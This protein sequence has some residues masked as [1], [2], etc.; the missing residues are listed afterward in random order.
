MIKEIVIEWNFEPKNFFEA[1]T[2]INYTDYEV[3]ISSGHAE[4]RLGPDYLDK[5]DMVVRALSQDLESRFMAVQVMTHEQY[6]LSKPSRYDLRLDGGRNGYFQVD[7]VVCT[8]SIGNVDLIQRDANGNILSDT[9][10]ERIDKKK[11]LAELAAKFRLKDASLDQMLRSYNASVSDP[12]NELIHL[13]EIRDAASK[14]FG[15]D[16]N[17]KKGLNISSSE[18]STLGR[19]ANSEP[20]TQ[21]RHRGQNPGILRDAETSELEQAR[22]IAAKIVENYLN[23]LEKESG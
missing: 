19:L 13:Y 22:R 4:A 2:V 21:G 7:S 8:T 15:N 12:K 17:T 18:W 9:K 6:K 11:R 10:Q 20:L 16:S 3:A 23:Y 5:V 14:R 1:E